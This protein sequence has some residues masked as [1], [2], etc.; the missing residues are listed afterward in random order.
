MLATKLGVDIEKS[1]DWNELI[2]SF[3]QFKY[4]GIF[5]ADKKRWWF[6]LV[7]DWWDEN[8]DGRVLKALTCQERVDALKIITK[9]ENLQPIN[10]QYENGSQSEK[11]WVNCVV[12][13]IPLDPF[14]ALR[15]NVLDLKS[16]EQPKY[17]DITSVLTRE[18]KALGFSVHH[19][20]RSRVELLKARLQP[21]VQ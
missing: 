12:S 21:N 8:Y 10:L 9:F 17:L 6:E 14:D 11:L 16:W 15:A 13:G 4:N 2:N 20:D 3:E 19:E 5:S 18:A 7:E 1:T